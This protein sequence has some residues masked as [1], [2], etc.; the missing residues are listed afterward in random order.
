MASFPSNLPS[1]LV[2][3]YAVSPVDQTARTDM[4]VGSAR[5][6]RR[7]FSTNDKV[8]LSWVFTDVEYQQFRVWHQSVI[9]G[10]AS[11]FDIYLHTGQASPN[12]EARF[13]GPYKVAMVSARL[14]WKVSADLEIRNA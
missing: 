1:P 10:G 12:V 4:E 6:R 9:A 2:D 13:V 7:T 5:V 11:W 8:S 14:I 3:G